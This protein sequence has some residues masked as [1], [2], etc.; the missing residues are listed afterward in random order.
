[1]SPAPVSEKLMNESSTSTVAMMA[2]LPGE[3]C[4]HW[5]GHTLEPTVT[6]L[7]RNF[8]L[9]EL[10]SLAEIG[11][12]G[13]HALIAARVVA[14]Q[15]NPVLGLG[16]LGA[17]APV[18]G[19]GVIADPEREGDGQPELGRGNTVCGRDVG[20]ARSQLLPFRRRRLFTC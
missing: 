13:E 7:T 9:A 3:I 19:V 18:P 10:I 5:V 1:M 15:A 6:V 16:A 14:G 12:R 11:V 2:V 20:V 8:S 4:S 17:G